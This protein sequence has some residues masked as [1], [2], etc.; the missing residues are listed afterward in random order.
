MSAPPKYKEHCYIFDM[1]GTLADLSHRI[2]HIQAASGDLKRKKDWPQFWADV[3]FDEPIEHMVRTYRMLRHSTAE[4]YTGC[5]IIIVSGR[6]ERCRVDTLEW[7]E[8][9]DLSHDGLYMRRDGDYRDDA[10]VK[11]ELLDVILAEG[12]KPIMAFDDRDRV[13][14]MWRARGIPC[15]QVAEGNF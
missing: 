2:H 1:D 13:V 4:S 6:M 8:R 11:S 12:W 10:T 14:K 3:P 5:G 15:A 7:L 9:N